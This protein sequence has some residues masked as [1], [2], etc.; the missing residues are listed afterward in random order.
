MAEHRRQSK[1]EVEQTVKI[2][3]GNGGVIEAKITGRP[4]R[5]VE[6]VQRK[7]PGRGRFTKTAQTMKLGAFKALIVE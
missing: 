5:Q 4:P 2:S 3:D 6:Y 1:L 7:T